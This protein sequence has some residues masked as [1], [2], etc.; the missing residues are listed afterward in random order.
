M[1]PH[2]DDDGDDDEDEGGWL[3]R[4]TFSMHSQPVL[5]ES[6]T[7]APSGFDVSPLISVTVTPSG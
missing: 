6:T 1:T 2:F 7:T 5:S 3:T 4:S